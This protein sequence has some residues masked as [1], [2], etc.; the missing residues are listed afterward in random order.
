ME[1]CVQVLCAV[2]TRD[3]AEA[4]AGRLVEDRLAACV[5]VLG[6]ISSTYRWRGAVERA[7]EFLLVAKTTRRAYPALERAIRALHPYE[8]PEITAV[9]VVEGS[10]DYLG[11]VRGEVRP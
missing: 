5:Q 4:I 2:D 6:P 11:W 8:V 1:D 7:E 10:A 9:P 3:R